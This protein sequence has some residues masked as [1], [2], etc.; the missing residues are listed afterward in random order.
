MNI[1]PNGKRIAFILDTI[2]TDSSLHLWHTLA[3]RIEEENGSFF[4]FPGGQLRNKSNSENLRNSI[5]SL[6]NS[7]N[8]DGLISWA[9]SIR[10]ETTL[11]ELEEFH[12]RFSNIPVITIGQKVKNLPSIKFDAYSGIRELVLH[13][14]NAHNIKKIA[15]IRGPENNV[16][17]EECLK[18]FKDT[19]SE[20][21][22]YTEKSEKLISSPYSWENGEAAAREL[23]E[24]RDLVPGKD[25]KAIISASDMLSY[26]A[27]NWFINKG[28]KT[29]KDFIIGGFNDSVISKVFT[30][31]L[32]TV[33][34]P[35]TILGI[36]TLSMLQQFFDGDKVFDKQLSA[37]PV[38]RESCGCNSLKSWLTASSPAKA[39]PKPRRQLYEDL[40]AI[41]R[42][43]SKFDRTRFESILNSFFDGK[44]DFYNK[45]SEELK[46]YF[47]NGGELANIYYAIALIKK[48][49]MLQ[50][51]YIE[52]MWRTVSFMIPQIQGQVA[53][54]R[55]Y[56][57]NR[58]N[59]VMSMLQ[60]DL[61]AIHSRNDLIKILKKSLPEIGI[62]TLS[63]V[64]YE[65]NDVS[66]YIGGFN[67]SDKIRT[68]EQVFNA[69]LLVPQNYSGDFQQGTFIVQ[70][71]F[72]E[73]RPLGY[74]IVNLANCDDF[75]YESLR[76][77][78]NN[79]LQSIFQFEEI[80]NARKIAERAEFEKTEFFANVGSDLCDPLKDLSSKISQMELNVNNGV[81][82]QDILGEQLIFLKSQI[83]SQLEKIE[84][85]VD[86]T[87]SQVA[88]LPMDKHLF[89][90]RQILPASMVA[91]LDMTYP[92]LYGDPDKYKKALQSI[93]DYSNTAPTIKADCRGIYINFESVKF[94]WT[95]TELQLAEKIFLLQYGELQKTEK[96]VSAF[97]PWP[98]IAGLPPAKKSDKGAIILSIAP[99][100]KE[101]FLFGIPVIKG[102]IE[103]QASIANCI[104]LWRPDESTIDET[105]KIHG[106]RKDE[107][108]SR[109]PLFC[110]S[111]S[112]IGHN[113][114]EML[115]QKIRTQNSSPVLFIGT[116]H[117]HYGKWATDS[118][119]IKISSMAEFDKIIEEFTPTLIVFEK[120]DEQSIKIVRQNSKTVLVPIIVLPD[121]IQSEE[122]V[123]ILCSHPR[124]ILCN[125]GA[126]E[127]DLFDARIHAI[128]S[129]D[130]I[131]PPHT[132]AI[133]K[134]AILYLNKNA[135]Q[136]IVRWKLADAV[137]VSED[138][139]TRI[140]HKE[141]GLSLWE[142]LNRY[143]IYIATKML[144]ET[145]DTVYEI[146]E[147]SGF[148]DQAYFCRVFK[149]IYGMPPGKIRSKN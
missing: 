76:T 126:A 121:T 49:A 69:G 22:L 26:D 8:F 72:I 54:S 47:A 58:S 79:T 33:H 60:S 127:S 82:D 119:S 74:L 123:E 77:A 125:R 124:I 89:D 92:L 27:A 85:L 68:T 147:H 95:K 41:F 130:E 12:E 94:D 122:E 34:M 99:E 83:E 29:P 131:L 39:K 133:V 35:F 53:R 10:G 91:S 140:F 120:I 113:F 36:E 128:L 98:N 114:V 37:Y 112:F 28:F 1:L 148:Q 70:P 46:D 143:R 9:S 55:N 102:E 116:T 101:P 45:L 139:L 129:G 65:N 73:N 44:P 135:S 75:V 142:Y 117:T 93:F 62:N 88:D 118:N 63:I 146:A 59:V 19:L 11:S 18:A 32:S 141:I 66:R 138:Y 13:F 104:I 108:L 64:F 78:V 105:V 61:L 16:T 136:Q 107:K 52:K 115:E 84:T 144:L 3:S 4:I 67:K 51:S 80:Q 21:G 30:P 57:D 100:E 2:H 81:L 50:E 40:C 103:E 42:F 86:L 23:F 87:R 97:I 6:V 145:N 43:Y 7:N 56:R 48:N 17:A 137:H 149:K 96:T 25:F 14:I 5:Y 24:E 110:F 111:Q 132:G 38:I 134:K 20:A 15:F 31:T 106:L 90:I 109:T 71:L